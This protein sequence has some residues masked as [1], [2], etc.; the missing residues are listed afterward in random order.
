ML[1][2]T[3]SADRRGGTGRAFDWGLIPVR[4]DVPIVLAGGLDASNVAAAVAQV[5]PHAVD[6]SG[7]V[8]SAPGIKDGEKMRQFMEEVQRGQVA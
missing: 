6:A 5:R 8:E 1:L 7:G 3:F 4:M 2:D